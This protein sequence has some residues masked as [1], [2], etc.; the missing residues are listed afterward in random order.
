M[1]TLPEWDKG[2]GADANEASIMHDASKEAL[3]LHLEMLASAG[4]DPQVVLPSYVGLHS[5][6]RF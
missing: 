1:F 2:K 4:I 3:R 5:F 6:Q